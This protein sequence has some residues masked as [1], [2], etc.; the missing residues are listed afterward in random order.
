MSIKNASEIHVVRHT[1]RNNLSW[2][3]VVG[4][5]YQLHQIVR[6]FVLTGH[7][8]GNPAKIKN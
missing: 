7:I 3:R 5:Y 8:G 6:Y 4:V 2:V 1:D